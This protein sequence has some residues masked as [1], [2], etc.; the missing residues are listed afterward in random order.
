M[1]FLRPRSNSFDEHF[2]LRYVFSFR[3]GTEAAAPDQKAKQKLQRPARGVRNSGAQ[4]GALKMRPWLV[5]V[6]CLLF[7]RLR[8]ACLPNNV[9]YAWQRLRDSLQAIPSVAYFVAII[10]VCG[11]RVL[12]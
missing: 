5:L 10:R 12:I 7:M 4:P 11:T 8:F 9:L 3:S 6:F 2:F 1:L